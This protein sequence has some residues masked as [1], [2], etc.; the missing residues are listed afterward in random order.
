MGQI[1]ITLADTLH[2]SFEGHTHTWR[3]KQILDKTVLFY[4]TGC[5]QLMPR[6]HWRLDGG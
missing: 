3:L 5:P 1:K 2:V 6:S 4:C